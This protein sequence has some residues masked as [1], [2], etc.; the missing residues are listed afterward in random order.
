MAV[1]F[2]FLGAK[3]PQAEVGASQH[4]DAEAYWEMSEIATHTL[5]GERRDLGGYIVWRLPAGTRTS[6]ILDP[7]GSITVLL[8][9]SYLEINM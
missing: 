5:A 8:F 6:L 4:L 7:E 3:K 2:I 9:Y 1:A